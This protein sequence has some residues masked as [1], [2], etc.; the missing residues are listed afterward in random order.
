[1]DGIEGYQQYWESH[2]AQVYM[3]DSTEINC[4]AA[5]FLQEN[6]LICSLDCQYLVNIGVWL[7]MDGHLTAAT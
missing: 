3:S 5:R 4:F 6:V 2:T 7:D 1:M